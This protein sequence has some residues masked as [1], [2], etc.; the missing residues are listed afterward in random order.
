MTVY[1]LLY[2]TYLNKFTKCYS[3]IIII[4]KDPNDIS[5]NPV[6]K[7]IP[8]QKLSIFDYNCCDRPH[9]LHA[10]IDPSTQKFITFDNIDFVFT[11]L[12]DAGYTLEYEM[13]KLV[14]NKKLICFISK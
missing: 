4:N 2:Q 13:A 10:F 5:L 6:L 12:V 11:K 8:N 14:K 3:N 9:C 7:I 1:Q